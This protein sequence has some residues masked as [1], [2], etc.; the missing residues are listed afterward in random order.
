MRIPRL[1]INLAVLLAICLPVHANA[2]TDIGPKPPS[3]QFDLVFDIPPV[4]LTGGQLLLCNNNDCTNPTT[5]EL[6]QASYNIRY[7][8]EADSCFV[9]VMGYN[10]PYYQLKLQ[11]ADRSRNSNIFTRSA[12][13]STY[14]VLVSEEDLQVDFQPSESPLITSRMLI[15]F[16]PALIATIALELIAIR[17]YNRKRS[18]KVSWWSVLAVNLVSVPVVWLSFPILP[19]PYGWLVF[20]DELFAF[21]IE[22]LLLYALNHK[23]GV[24]WKQ[25]YL[26]SLVINATSLLAFALGLILLWGLMWL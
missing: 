20:L 26:A 4:E 17:L 21:G 5:V 15:C 3:M 14:R 1:L 11:F 12:Y 8:C 10:S 6:V 9:F 7:G 13:D 2:M 16:L 24:S 23:H 18:I 22:G 19:V 25:A